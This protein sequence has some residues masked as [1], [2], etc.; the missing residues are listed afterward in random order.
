MESEETPVVIGILILPF[1]GLDK[2]GEFITKFTFT[3]IKVILMGLS[4]L[5]VL[6]FI[7]H[8]VPKEFFSGI[9]NLIFWLHSIFGR[10]TSSLSLS[11][12]FVLVICYLITIKLMWNPT[13]SNTFV[14]F[15]QS[16]WIFLVGYLCS[17]LGA[18]Q[19][20]TFIVLM[21]YGLI[22]IYYD[23][24][25]N[26]EMITKIKNIFKKK[27]EEKKVDR[28]ATPDPLPSQATATPMSRLMKTKTHLSEIKN[29]MQLNVPQESETKTKGKSEVALESDGY[30]KILFYACAA[31]VLFKHLWIVFLSFIP[32]T[33]YAI[34]SLCKALGI[35]NHIEAQLSHQINQFKAWFEARRYALIPI[36][37]PG[38]IQL[39]KKLH[40]VF[41]SKL[42][43]FVDDISASI[44][45][46]FLI[47]A[48]AGL[49]VFSFVQIY[50]EAITVAQLSHN[51]INRTL[52]LNPELVESLPINMQNLNDVI[53]NA[54]QYSRGTIENYLGNI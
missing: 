37:L 6:R 23:E 42:K 46:V 31:T 20:P 38:I 52:I 22:G 2:L 39:N 54:Y 41:C 13:T 50:S 49:S 47:V 17:F 3:H 7:V 12:I 18:L 29:K 21:T 28:E 35:W 11:M 48:A 10:I 45:I 14:I 53:D 15:G 44:M 26:N 30:F 5:I 25:N 33:F 32:I 43:T 16:A 4:S 8:Y 27:E 9:F 36:F 51:L 1:S 19:I 34:K 40:K 24:T